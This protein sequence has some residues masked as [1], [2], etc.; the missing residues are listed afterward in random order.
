M[1]RPKVLITN[2]DRNGKPRSDYWFVRI[3]DKSRSFTQSSWVEGGVKWINQH[4][5]HGR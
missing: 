5:K 2:A 4:L 3:G 1:T